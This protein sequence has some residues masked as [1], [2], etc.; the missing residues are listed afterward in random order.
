MSA[1]FEVR[2]VTGRALL[3]RRFRSLESVINFFIQSSS[4]GV[5]HV[6]LEHA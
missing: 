1:G 6:N 3:C 4:A 2:A 5:A